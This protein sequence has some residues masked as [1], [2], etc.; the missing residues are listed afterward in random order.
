MSNVVSFPERHQ[1]DQQAPNDKHRGPQ[2]ED[3]Y[4]RIANELLEAI[5][6]SHA[7]PVTLRQLRVVLAVIRKTY[8]FNKKS[9]RISDSQI[10]ESSGLSRQNVNKAKRELIAIGVLFMDGHKLAVNKHPDQWNFTSQP[11]KD[12]LK[13]TRDS[14]SKQETKSVSKSGSHK[15]QKDTTPSPYGEESTAGADDTN[16]TPVPV[17]EPQP[18]PQD[19]TPKR[20]RRSTLPNCPHQAILDQW[21]EIMPE[22]RQPLRSLW[23]KGTGGSRELAAR[24]KQGFGI[25]NEQTGEPLYVD[26]SSGIDWW[27]R[28]F[29]FLRRSDFLMRDDSRFFGI[30]WVCKADN[31]RKIM[32]FKY[33]GDLARGD[34]GD[35]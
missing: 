29:K 22:K 21:L 34:G 26:A 11:Q 20:P 15:R 14:V 31:F 35:A 25:R 6:N 1:D 33:H 19:E 23:A 28:F 17:D 13:Q 24:W 12:N 5:S 18:D 2:V 30:D 9:D 8:G 4:T 3:G 32:E 16:P 10:A 27:C 7:F